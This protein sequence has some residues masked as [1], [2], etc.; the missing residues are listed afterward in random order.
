MSPATLSRLFEAFFKT[1]GIS[2]TGL[3]R[4]SHV[5]IF[6]CFGYGGRILVERPSFLWHN[7]VV[8]A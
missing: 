8:E 1:K 3:A 6:V 5:G 7:C 4:I 2:G